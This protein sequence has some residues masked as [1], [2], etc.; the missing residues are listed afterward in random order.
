MPSISRGATAAIQI[1][2]GFEPPLPQRILGL[3]R[4]NGVLAH[5]WARMGRKERNSGR[6]SGYQ[7]SGTLTARPPVEV[8]LYFRF[9][10]RP[11]CRMVSIT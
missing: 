6:Q 2:W 10:S 7:H 5:A 1:G 11:V 8:S 4:R 9:M 3:L